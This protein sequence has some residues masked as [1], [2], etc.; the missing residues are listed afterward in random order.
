[1]TDYI[2]KVSNRFQKY[3]EADAKL[4]KLTGFG[5]EQLVD[6]FAAGYTLKAPVERYFGS[7]TDA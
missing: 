2:N 3:E 4:R 5:I 6:M 7:G 1:M